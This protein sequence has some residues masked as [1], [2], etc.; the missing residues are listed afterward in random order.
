MKNS[1]TETRLTLDRY[2]EQKAVLVSE[3]DEYLVLDNKFLPKGLKEGDSVM[4]QIAHEEAYTK[5]KQKKAKE[6]LNEILKSG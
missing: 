6:L 4:L 5:Q 3:D 2:E 1:S